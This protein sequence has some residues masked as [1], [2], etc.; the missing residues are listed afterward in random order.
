MQFIIASNNRDKIKEIQRILRVRQNNAIPYTEL[1]EKKH[2]PPEGNRSYT[3]NASEKALF[4]SKFLPEELVIADDSG[5][6][7]KAQPGILGVRTARDLANY[8]TAHE[9]AQHIIQLVQ[10]RDRSFKMTTVLTC[11][12]QG[13]IL[14]TVPGILEGEIARTERGTAGE[15]FS[16][17][18]IP[19][20][21]TKT[22]AQMAFNEAYPYLTRAQAA[23]GL[24]RFLKKKGN[25]G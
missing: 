6:S 25:Q 24:D 20:N 2:F 16:R 13:R 8:P 14:K 9:Y 1:I 11:A 7:L 4:I 15:G 23:E 3:E 17:I 19:E 10:G 22:L 5:L 21:S 18:L 12:Y